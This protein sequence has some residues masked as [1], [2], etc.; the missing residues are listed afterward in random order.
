M[1]S[2]QIVG[3]LRPLSNIR[4]GYAYAQNHTKIW[5]DLLDAEIVN[6]Q[7]WNG[8]EVYFYTRS[9]YAGE[10]NYNYFGGLTEGFYKTLKTFVDHDAKYYCL[11]YPMLDIGEDIRK[12][13]KNPSCFKGFTEEFANA[14]SEKCKLVE[15]VYPEDFAHE[16]I[17]IGDSHSLSMTH[18][19]SPVKKLIGKTL[20]SAVKN[21]DLFTYAENTKAKTISFMLG[22]IDIRHH[23]FRLENPFESMETLVHDYIDH[24]IEIAD[25]FDKH[26]EI[27]SPT[28]IEWEGRKIPSSGFY[29]GS[30]FY[31]SRDERIKMVKR[32]IELV[33]DRTK[34]ISNVS[35]VKYPDHWYD[36]DGKEYA[37]MMMERP[38]NTHVALKFARLNE[39]GWSHSGL[40][41]LDEFIKE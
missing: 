39:F 9:D 5:S 1:T 21:R 34:D 17:T 14:V 2:K 40:N 3:L 8:D 4:Y 12:R 19:N 10:G 37:D 20:Y 26:I 16:R 13:L 27:C 25:T 41:A 33:Q 35:M 6:G 15:T 30:S 22:S 18:K 38:T 11:D 24:C 23:L 32:F 36:M 29:K 28:P 31:G 7:V